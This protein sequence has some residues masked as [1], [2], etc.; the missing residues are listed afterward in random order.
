MLILFG[1]SCQSNVPIEEDCLF[2]FFSHWDLWNNGTLSCAIGTI[3]KLSM[4]TLSRP[5]P[6]VQEL[7]NI[8]QFCHWKFNNI[9]S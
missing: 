5:L 3:G 1:Q 7:R 2:V 6:T 4:S 9:Q 8:E